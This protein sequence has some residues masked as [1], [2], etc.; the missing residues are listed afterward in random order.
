MKTVCFAEL[1]PGM[2]LLPIEAVKPDSKIYIER[3]A[4]ILVDCFRSAAEGFWRDKNAIKVLAPDVA[5]MGMSSY[6]VRPGT[7]WY[8]V[9]DKEDLATF[10]SVILKELDWMTNHMEE[11]RMVVNV[12]I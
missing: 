8:V 12:S 2:V 5:Y 4:F 11:C 6:E 9:E 3:D 10:K 1:V 7:T